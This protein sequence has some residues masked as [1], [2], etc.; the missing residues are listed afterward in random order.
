MG[1]DLGGHR[2][3]AQPVFD[4]PLAEQQEQSGGDATGGM[5]TWRGLDAA[6][7]EDRFQG[8]AQDQGV[9]GGKVIG[10][11]SGQR[12]GNGNHLRRRMPTFEPGAE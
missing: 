11:P 6:R 7:F 8:G 3:P 5:V 4:S 2:R 10:H 9:M 12:F 1:G